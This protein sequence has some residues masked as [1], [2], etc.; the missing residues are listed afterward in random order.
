MAGLTYYLFSIWIDDD[1]ESW[2]T[3]HDIQPDDAIVFMMSLVIGLNCSGMLVSVL[4]YL[5]EGVAS[6]NS[7]N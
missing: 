2:L 6:A 1:D 7:M 5:V 4:H 3:G